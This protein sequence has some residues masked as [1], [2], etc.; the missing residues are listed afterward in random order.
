MVDSLGRWTCWLTVAMAAIV[1]GVVIGRY[2]F[3]TGSIALQEL[4]MYLHAL[5]FMLGIPFT[6][7]HDQHVRV[8][9]VYSRL[10]TRGRARVNLVGHV[11]LLMPVAVCIMI[12]SWPYVGRSWGVLEG[13]P[14]VGGIPAIFLLKTLIPVMALLLLMMAVAQICRYLT[15]L[16]NAPGV[17]DG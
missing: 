11:L 1:T 2:L 3:N 15:V 9:I 14:E 7:Q 4:A 12:Y 10:R 17:D 8:D 13:S 16:R 6:L 5:V